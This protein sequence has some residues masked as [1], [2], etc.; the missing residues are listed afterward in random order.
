VAA[1]PLN[2]TEPF[3]GGEMIRNVNPLPV[4]G[5][6]MATLL[7]LVV[8]VETLLTVGGVPGF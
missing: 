8:L 3:A 5:N 1:A 2:P 4:A 7:S 6:V